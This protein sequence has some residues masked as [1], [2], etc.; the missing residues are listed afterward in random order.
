M[1]RDRQRST[2]MRQALL[3]RSSHP[4]PC[5]EV[6]APHIT[7]K[8]PK[9]SGGCGVVMCS[10]QHSGEGCARS[11]RGCPSRMRQ[12]N[13]EPKLPV[14]VPPP[15]GPV[16]PRLRPVLPQQVAQPGVPAHQV[17]EFLGGAKTP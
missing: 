17:R 8:S 2:H 16:L 10:G 11:P 13:R 6:G 1:S 14:V 7:D 15:L 5:D 12:V 4:F 3:G 9:A